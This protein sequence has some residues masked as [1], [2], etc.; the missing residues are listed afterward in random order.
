MTIAITSL[1]IYFLLA[2]KR[3]A[4]GLGLVLAGLPLYMVRTKVMGIPTTG[5]ELVLGVFLLSVLLT[6]LNWES[7]RKIKGLKTVNLLAAGMLLAAGIGT[8]VSP[9]PIKALGQLK[10]FFLE[11]MLF[12]YASV[13]VMKGE[14]EV[15][16]ALRLL[17]TAAS[18]ISLFGIFQYWT[19]VWLPV[20]F[21]GYGLEIKR[22]TSIFEYP[23]ALALYLAPLFVMFLALELKRY[24][25]WK[26]YWGWVGLGLMATALTL[27]YSR[28]AWLGVLAAVF[29]LLVRQSGISLRRWKVWAVIGLLVL[30]PVLAT[31]FK[32]TF[33]DGAS[34]ER[35]M[36]YRVGAQKIMDS[37]LLGN[38]L[39][40]FR[41]TL[42]NSAYAGELLNYPHN[43]ILNFWLETGLLGL[44]AFCLLVF[45]A[46]RQ[47]RS[48]PTVL[49]FAA[50]LFLLA[51]FT[52]GMVDVPYFKNDLS[53]M[54]WFVLSLFYLE[55]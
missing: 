2:V 23:N 26:N 33:N 13:L 36:L 5:L 21:W 39:Y 9:E 4:W 3:P 27:T 22:I 37:P 6:N 47:Y 40:G 43:I 49:K 10:A 16:V 35:L 42:E 15:R 32:S 48:R 31:R 8:I 52:H 41:Q 53:L 18:A 50:G 24:G 7:W 55:E 46:L 25:I 38:G 17:F 51:M 20:R 34:S 28:G 14:R 30:S 19:H 29:V 44:L 54:F 11:P 12:F 45:L 1:I